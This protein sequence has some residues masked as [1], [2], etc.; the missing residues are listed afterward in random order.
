[1]HSCFGRSRVTHFGRRNAHRPIR[2]LRRNPSKT[3]RHLVANPLGDANAYGS[4]QVDQTRKDF[5]IVISVSGFVCNSRSR[6]GRINNHQVQQRV[7]ARFGLA[8]VESPIGRCAGL[9]VDPRLLG[10]DVNRS[11]QLLASR[12]RVSSFDAHAKDGCMRVPDAHTRRSRRLAEPAPPACED[13][14]PPGCEKSRHRS[15]AA[16][17]EALLRAPSVVRPHAQTAATRNA[18]R[19]VCL[20]QAPPAVYPQR[21]AGRGSSGD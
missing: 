16:A 2:W 19:A 8:F 14:N 4:R 11:R 7:G 9:C 6:W 20:P 5:S 21:A 3:Q 15:G 18:K 13:A 1:M 12:V 17:R 10:E